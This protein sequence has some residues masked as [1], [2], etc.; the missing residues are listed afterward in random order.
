MIKNSHI[1]VM[2]YFLDTS[3]STK[4]KLLASKDQ[5]L[6]R[7]SKN[8]KEL[9]LGLNEHRCLLAILG[10]YTDEGY[11][12]DISEKGVTF[13]T[14]EFCKWMGFKQDSKGRFG[15][16]RI[17]E[18]MH[19]LLSLSR[20]YFSVYFKKYMRREDGHD[21]Y[22]IIALPSCHLIDI[23]YSA[24]NVTEE[25]LENGKVEDKVSKIHVRIFT[26]FFNEGYYKLFEANFYQRLKA[27]L[28]KSNRRPTKYHFNFALWH[29]KQNKKF[30]FAEINVNKLA[31]LLKIPF[32]SAH[33]TRARSIVRTLYKDFQDLGYLKKYE[34]DIPAQTMETKD[35]L[36]LVDPIG[37]LSRGETGCNYGG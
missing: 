15:S 7:F 32:D 24:S 18:A 21:V 10:K 34:I 29:L 27:L 16:R 30:D 12:T 36:Y 6:Q 14:Y 26:K 2:G 13:T 4:N 11:G 37:L 9:D 5:R 17:K 28:N 25:E 22:E 31:I 20:R 8:F 33:V 1:K 23:I 3:L 35:R 19:A